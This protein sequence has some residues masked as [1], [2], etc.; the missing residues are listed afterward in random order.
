MLYLARLKGKD[1]ADLYRG[2]YNMGVLEDVAQTD[3][4]IAWESGLICEGGTFQD[5]LF[6]PPDTKTTFPWGLLAL[7]G[8][9]F[10]P[11]YSNNE[12]YSFYT[13]HYRELLEKII[14]ISRACFSR[15]IK[16]AQI[17]WEKLNAK[18]SEDAEKT[19]TTG[20]AA[21][22]NRNTYENVKSLGGVS[23]PTAYSSTESATST[24]SAVS[25]TRELSTTQETKFKNLQAYASVDSP[26]FLASKK[27]KNFIIPVDFKERAEY[28]ASI[29]ADW[30]VFLDGYENAKILEYPVF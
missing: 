22:T 14:E 7:Q 1:A 24:P 27:L 19:N 2:E 4:G 20:T 8:G 3:A 17:E 15:G 16:K 26:Y 6:T 5:S 12:G 30:W 10:I 11:F 18:A 25:I 28:Y 23:T 21:Q 13:S 9:G 29:G